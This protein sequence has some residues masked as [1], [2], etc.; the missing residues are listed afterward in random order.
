MMYK[1][2]EFLENYFNLKSYCQCE[3]NDYNS[4]GEVIGTCDGT[5]IFGKLTGKQYQ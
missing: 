1:I 5:E 2:K 4:L 3:R